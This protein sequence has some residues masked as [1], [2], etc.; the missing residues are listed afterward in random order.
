M[1]RHFKPILSTAFAVGI[2]VVAVMLTASLAKG[3]YQH[4]EENAFEG[5]LGH[6]EKALITGAWSPEPAARLAAVLKQ[7]EFDWGL[8]CGAACPQCGRKDP[9]VTP[10]VLDVPELFGPSEAAIDMIKRKTG[11]NAFRGTVF[12]GPEGPTAKMLNQEEP[13]EL[14]AFDHVLRKS[15]RHVID[16]SGIPTPDHQ[17]G[18]SAIP[19]SFGQHA[20]DA[21]G[22]SADR[23]VESGSASLR[24]TEVWNGRPACPMGT[25]CGQAAISV[26]DNGKDCPGSSVTGIAAVAPSAADPVELLRQHGSGL[27]EVANTLEENDLYHEADAI[28]EVAQRLRL[29]ART[30]RSAGETARHD[31][32][33]FYPA[34]GVTRPLG[35]AYGAYA[36]E[37]TR[38]SDTCCED[39]CTCTGTCTVST[40]P[41][42]KS[43]RPQYSA[44]SLQPPSA[45]QHDGRPPKTQRPD[46]RVSEEVQAYEFIRGISR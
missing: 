28:R 2:L 21:V 44:E 3:P 25:D 19:D 17:F 43:G 29:K 4:G 38:C 13:A 32:P 9:K 15:G 41:A 18:D 26:T 46:E 1:R 40:C 36:A 12:E 8:K 10:V 16:H 6:P 20:E 42:K 45:P 23:I 11:I 5:P 37:E 31:S 14:K 27:D 39:K 22:E 24:A 34:H 30:L 7:N 35:I 33:P